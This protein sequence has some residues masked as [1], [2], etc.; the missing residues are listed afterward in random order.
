MARS[1]R[2]IHRRCMGTPDAH[3]WSEGNQ[4]KKFCHRAFNGIFALVLCASLSG[5]DQAQLVPIKASVQPPDNRMKRYV[6]PDILCIACTRAFGGVCQDGQDVVAVRI[7]TVLLLLC[8]AVY[9][10][11]EYLNPSHIHCAVLRYPTAMLLK[12]DSLPI[13]VELMNCASTCRRIF[14]RTCSY[15]RLVCILRSRIKVD[16][17]AMQSCP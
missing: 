8:P 10:G 7:I 16:S 14:K 11:V 6:F 5:V 15:L 13:N 2:G 1:R 9:G 3:H 17:I 12:F 4:G